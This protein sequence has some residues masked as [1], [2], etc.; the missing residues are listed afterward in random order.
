MGGGLHISP[1]PVRGR[2]RVGGKITPKDCSLVGMIRLSAA[3][4]L[5]LLIALLCAYAGLREPGATLDG[6]LADPAAHDGA[7]IYSPH[8]SV[9]G[10][11]MEGGFI[12]SDYGD[13]EAIGVPIERKKAMLE[14]FLRNDRWKRGA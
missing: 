2:D 8:E 6:C 4:V 10:R 5:A 12:L 13:G 11:V 9:I 3:I 1:P 14:A 7:T